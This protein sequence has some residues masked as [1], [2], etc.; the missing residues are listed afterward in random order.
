[1]S[2]SSGDHPL[3]NFQPLG[4]ID[5]RGMV[6]IVQCCLPDAAYHPIGHHQP[7]RHIHRWWIALVVQG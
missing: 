1:M 5:G 2:A 6:I 4:G 3:G 7:L